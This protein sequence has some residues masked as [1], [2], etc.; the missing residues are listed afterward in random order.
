M[1]KFK[2]T[3]QEDKKAKQENNRKKVKKEI[4]KTLDPS[5]LFMIVG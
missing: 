5:P 4:A 1:G 2:K 3:Q